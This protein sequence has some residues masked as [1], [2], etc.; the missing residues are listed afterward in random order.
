MTKISFINR[1]KETRDLEKYLASPPSSIL[2]VYGPKS[3]GKSTLLK[4]IVDNLNTKKYAVNYLNLRGVIIYNFKTFLDV[5]FQ[6]TKSQ[7]IKEVFSGLT[8]NAGFFKVSLEDEEMLE[9]NAFKIME[10]QIKNTNKKGIK[11][12]IV[13]D[14]IQL[15]KNIYLHDERYLLDEVFNLFIRLTK[16][17]H[18][19]HII[20]ATSDSYFIEQIYNSASMSKTCTYYLVDHLEK[21]DVFKWLNKYPKRFPTEKEVKYVWNN[22]GGS[23]WELWHVINDVKHGDSIKDAVEKRIHDIQARVFDFYAF[24][25]LPDDQKKRFVKISQEIAKKGFYQLNKDDDISDLIS[26]TVEKDIW[27]YNTITQKITA[28]SKSLEKVFVRMFS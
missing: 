17:T 15:L 6:K 14:E 26:K 1:K 2:F 22:L 10:E 16:E 13:L 9:K 7:K 11:P 24:R 19:C 3:T 28:N 18:S 20:C 27:F 5:F 21:T 12:V 25:K 23:P 4:K 8:L